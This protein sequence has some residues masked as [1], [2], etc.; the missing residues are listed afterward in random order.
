MISHN[1]VGISAT[2]AGAGV[3]AFLIFA[4]SVSRTVDI[5]ETFWPAVGRKPSHAGQAG[6]VTSCVPP[7]GRIGIR[8]TGVWLT[9]IICFHR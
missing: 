6:A 7:G 8:T 5:V 1:T 9:G 2:Q 3:N 4:S